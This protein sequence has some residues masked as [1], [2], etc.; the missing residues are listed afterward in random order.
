[1]L[2]LYLVVYLGLGPMRELVLAGDR[3]L[4]ESERATTT[5]ELRA[6]GQRFGRVLGDSGMR[7]LLLMA[8]AALGGKGSLAAKGPKLPGFGKAALLSPVRTGVRLEAAGQVG[9]VVLGAEELVVVLAPTAVAANALGPG[10]GAP[11]PKKGRLTGRPTKP[12]ANEKTESGLK[13]IE[14]ENESA[15]LLAENGYDVEQ[16]PPTNWKGKNPDYK[17]NGEYADC[18]A[19]RTDKP[20]SILSTV[21]E[22]VNTGQAR[23]IVLNLDDSQVRLDALKKTTLGGPHCRSKRNHRSKRQEN[24]PLLPMTHSPRMS[25]L[26]YGTTVCPLSGNPSQTRTSIVHTGQSGR[27]GVLER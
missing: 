13:A 24:H 20:H 3:L 17:L 18:Y 25:I 12:S 15:R 6:A 4:E 23:R 9:S 21:A 22:K 14:R 27:W 7:V 11:P 16:N 5:G 19:P 10:G 26:Q 2:T 1:M 8:T